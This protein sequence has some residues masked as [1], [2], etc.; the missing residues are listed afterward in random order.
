MVTTIEL[1]NSIIA[2]KISDMHI[3]L[4]AKIVAYDYTKQKAI[5][6]PLINQKLTNGEVIKLPQ[7]YNVPVVQ[8]V[9]GGASITLPVK[10]GDKV[11]LIFA[12]KSLEEWLKSGK[13][14]TPDDPRSNNLTDAIAILGLRDFGTNSPAQNNTDLLIKYSGSEIVLKPNGNIDI[15]ATNC[16]MTID[17]VNIVGDINI[18]GN[19]TISGTLSVAGKDFAT[20]THGGIQSG[21]SNT[22]IVN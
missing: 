13:Q 22:G 18:T 16:N 6:Q 17:T 9:S 12:D 4:P 21:G 10:I 15:N 8:L 7:I 2:N 3:C 5:V 14:V 1:L 11:L 19:V 20:H